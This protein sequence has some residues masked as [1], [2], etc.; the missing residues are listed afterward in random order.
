MNQFTLT[1]DEAAIRAVAQK[2]TDLGN[3]LHNEGTLALDL[4]GS[5]SA[6][7]WSGQARDATC[8]EI[9]GLG[10]HLQGFQPL[11]LQAAESLQALA[12][13]V[14]EKQKTVTLLNSL[15]LDAIADAA[16]TAQHSTSPN[17]SEH[18][19]AELADD[20]RR[21][22]TRFQDA[23]EEVRKACVTASDHIRTKVMAR[24]PASALAAFHASGATGATVSWGEGPVWADNHTTEQALAAGQPLLAS[25]LAKEDAQAAVA[26]VRSAAGD[27]AVMAQFK[28]QFGDRARDP[29]F[30]YEFSKALTAA[31][32]TDVGA[33][34]VSHL[35]QSQHGLFNGDAAKVA[36]ADNAWLTKFLGTT[37]TTSVNPASVT[38]VPE[39]LRQEM[40]AWRIGFLPELKTAG[41]Q[42]IERPNENYSFYGYWAISQYVGASEVSPGVEFF[43]DVGLDVLAWDRSLG[44]E[45]RTQDWAAPHQIRA[46]DPTYDIFGNVTDTPKPELVLANFTNSDNNMLQDPITGFLTSAKTSGDTARAFLT[47]PIDTA[48]NSPDGMRY[49][50]L[51]R[52]KT[53][54][55]N[56]PFADGG[57]L[58]GDT[59]V[60]ADHDKTS[61]PATH[62]AQEFIDL[63]LLDLSE[64]KE[65]KSM[66]QPWKEKLPVNR[67]SLPGLRPAMGSVLAYHIDSLQEV[68]SENTEQDA[69]R[70][71]HAVTDTPAQMYNGNYGV[72]FPDPGSYSFL[73]K[74]LALDHPGQALDVN[75]PQPN[76]FQTVALAQ[77]DYLKNDLHHSFEGE[78]VDRHRLLNSISIGMKNL[79]YIV[80]SGEQSLANHGIA[81]DVS[82][83]F[84]IEKCKMI[85]AATPLEKLG[86]IAAGAKFAIGVGSNAAL[87][88][89]LSTTNG[90]SQ[91]KGS[92]SYDGA[93][94]L[95][96]E[97]TLAAEINQRGDW[98]PGHSP[99]DWAKANPTEITSDNKFYDSAGRVKAI[100]DM[101]LMEF[102][103]FRKWRGSESE[104][105]YNAYETFN[106]QAG[107]SSVLGREQ[108]RTST[109]T[110]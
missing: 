69:R 16:R 13:V 32:Y 53:F 48:P 99:A 12:R 11:F 75:N 60:A 55:R 74:D 78:K 81:K 19:R 41:H 37:L 35:Y 61:A 84:I 107:I 33:S 100:K 108:A 21:L 85:I 51:E 7:E 42:K 105:G 36:A 46:D 57:A 15:W 49:L 52:P 95:M 54:D 97:G 28:Q 31:G 91:A 87:T 94:A 56:N 76:A 62:A 89:A 26:M 47:T 79:A 70:Y 40:G 103:A 25:R 63:Y 93:L 82:N 8:V 2:W 92:I 23:H 67:T 9:T 6:D 110:P 104:N 109:A 22:T 77:L 73:V 102:E 30:A 45:S 98:P 1:I 101:S 4:P 83:K 18:A 68:L 71:L 58:L 20:Q 24:V 27:P 90:A 66:F 29:Y 65:A 39:A 17:V 44:G 3:S 96:I 86:P 10:H 43:K 80:G 14:H 64:T 59:I 38:A 88:H 106:T 5:V 34:M 72:L 50:M